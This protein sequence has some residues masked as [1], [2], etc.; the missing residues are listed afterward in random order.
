[1][2]ASNNNALPYFMQEV[3]IKF[4]LYN[5]LFTALPFH[6]IEKTGVLLSLF[7]IACEEGFAKGDSPAAIIQH[8]FHQH[9]PTVSEKQQVDLL[10]RFIQYCERQVVLFDA[11]EDAAFTQVHDMKGSGT[12]ADVSAFMDQT[13]LAVLKE[14]GQDLSIRL[15]LTAHPTQFYPGAV[16]GIINDLSKSISHNDVTQINTHLQQLGKTPFLLRQKPTPLDEAYSL[17]WYLEYVFYPAIGKI[18]DSLRNLF[19]TING[20]APRI[21]MGFWPGGDRDGNPFV[22]AETT[23]LVSRTLR[24]AILRCYY[25]DVRKLKRRLTFRGVEQV[26][27][28]LEHTLYE[29]LFLQQGAD[30]SVQQIWTPLREIRRVLIEQHSGFFVDLVD[31]LM[32]KLSVFGLHFASLD[33]RQE[34][35]VHTQIW[36]LLFQQEPRQHHIEYAHWDEPSKLEWLAQYQGDLQIPDADAVLQDALKLGAVITKIQAENGVKACDRYIISQC[37][38]PSHVM[39][40][41]HLLKRGGMNTAALDIVPLFE[42]IVDLQTS[43][44]SMEMLFSSPVYQAHLA[45]RGMVQ[46][47]MLGFSD[48]TKDGGYLTANWSIYQ[49]KKDLTALCRRY[50]IKVVFFDGRGGPP[51]RG[52]GKTHQ[53]YASMGREISNQEIQL[54]IQGQTISSNFGTV[55]AAQFNIEQLL[56]AAIRSRLR[57]PQEDTLNE[58][59]TQLME[60]L[61]ETALQA[62]LDLRDDPRFI[63]YLLDVSPLKFYSETNIGS[64]PARR[65]GRAQIE[66]T[67]LRAIPFVG[68]WSQI[69]QNLTGY[70]G[71]GFALEA[72]FQAGKWNEM[73]AFYQDNAFLRTLVDNCEMAMLKCYFPL[74]RYVEKDER[75]G[76]IWTKVYAEYERTRYY[77]RLLTGQSDLMHRY[78]VEQL[79]VQMRERIILPL[80]TIQQFALMQLRSNQDQGMDIEPDVW[81]KLVVRTSF[82]IIN[83][84]RNSA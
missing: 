43:A 11:L 51:A 74:T 13:N 83:A 39:E 31:N 19:S 29:Q 36:S 55:D 47:I 34:S 41:F 62:Y 35:R 9:L 14:A 32:G 59:Q 54:T 52:G 33:I 80:T 81:Q 68:A 64:R 6:K 30:F 46:T 27:A 56:H 84:G 82:G 78:P 69:K 49:A 61:S 8:F 3:G 40:V 66:L 1:M 42:T 20:S 58:M 37:H 21:E 25:S 38:K 72:I 12:L 79:S 7:L 10:F 44:S 77:L 48:G 73:V 63:E 67:D 4:Q 60:Q 2:S 18:Q 57:S 70:Y 23:Y 16:L 15:V 71:V 22:N 5:S 53:F 45:S 17:I 50:G 26:I 76:G 28:D 75:Y 24:G 65:S